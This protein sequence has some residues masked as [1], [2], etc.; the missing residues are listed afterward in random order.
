VTYLIDTDWLINVF[1]GVPSAVQAVRA[2]PTEEVGVSIVSHGEVFEGAFGFPD[3]QDRLERY[4][5]FLGQ[6]STIPLSG[7]IMEIF[8]SVR[9][10]LRRSG[11]RISDFDLLIGATAVHHNLIV[12]TRNVRH[13]TRIPGLQ[14]YQPT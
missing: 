5:A 1:V 2:L 8:G 6:Y 7:P 13:F 3:T 11:Q 10:D 12:L 14:L 9:S 4:R